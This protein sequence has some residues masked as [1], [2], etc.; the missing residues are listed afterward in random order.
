[1]TKRKRTNNDAQNIA[2]KTKD[3]I[4]LKTGVVIGKIWNDELLTEH[5][6]IARHPTAVKI[7]S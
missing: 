2:Q 4:A 7:K 6:S 1:M 5:V 3:R